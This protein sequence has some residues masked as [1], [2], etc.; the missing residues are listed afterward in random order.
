MLPC[1]YIEFATPH[2]KYGIEPRV[3]FIW[4]IEIQRRGHAPFIGLGAIRHYAKSDGVKLDLGAIIGFDETG[5]VSLSAIFSCHHAAF[6]VD[7]S[8]NVPSICKPFTLPSPR[9]QDV[10]LCDSQG[11]SRLSYRVYIVVAHQTV[12]PCCRSFPQF[13]FVFAL[14]ATQLV[15]IGKHLPYQS[16]CVLKIFGILGTLL[17]PSWN[18]NCSSTPKTSVSPS[19]VPM[20]FL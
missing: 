9:C 12:Y 1:V 8:T 16:H 3:S 14:K 18:Q 13:T 10:F 17:P 20:R 19:C 6:F 2:T 5:N 4:R 11:K 15:L 7:I